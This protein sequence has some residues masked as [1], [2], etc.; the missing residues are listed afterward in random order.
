[1]VDILTYEDAA[2]LLGKPK[3]NLQK[4]L[5]LGAASV[6]GGAAL[7][8]PALAAFLD[9]RET[10][11]DACLDL[12]THLHDALVG[13]GRWTRTQRL[14]AA[15][16]V[17]AIA[18]FFDALSQA[19]LPMNFSELEFTRE[20]QIQIANGDCG[21]AP[22]GAREFLREVLAFGEVQVPHPAVALEQYTKQLRGGLYL[23]M[24]RRLKAFVEGLACWERLNDTKKA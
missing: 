5:Q 3:N 18:S 22:E 21:K 14:V 7:T 1:M 8:M 2:S 12:L 15:H 4:Y 9:A 23:E 24:T 13:I 17:L 16:G 11:V 6:L 19:R 20:E 10:F